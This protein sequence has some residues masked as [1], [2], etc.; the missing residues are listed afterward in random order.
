MPKFFLT[1]MILAL[2]PCCLEVE[3]SVPGFPQM[4]A[5]FAASDAMIQGTLAVNFIGFCIGSLFWG[6]VAESWGKRKA[7][8]SG[9]TVLLA[10]AIGCVLAPSINTLL[11]ARFF[12]GIGASAAAVLVFSM[13]A[14]RFEGEKAARIIGI[15]NAILTTLMALAPVIGALVNQWIGWQGNYA[16]L[17]AICSI[18]WLALL[19]FLPET[20]HTHMPFHF[21]TLLKTIKNLLTLQF[22]SLA[23][24]PSLL[25]AGYLSFIG[26]ATFLYQVT[27]QLSLAS[28]ALHQFLIIGT[29]AITSL[30]AAAITQKLGTKRT[31]HGAKI[32]CYSSIGSLFLISLYMPE[33]NL[34][35]VCMMGFCIG[36]ALYYPPIFTASMAIFPNHTGIASSLLMSLRTALTSSFISLTAFSFEGSLFSLT[37]PLLAIVA[38]F[39]ICNLRVKD[40]ITS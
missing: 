12:Q 18:S 9:S 4:A 10:G 37:L 35:T 20:S 36:F 24:A 23:T 5:Y 32:L 31:L 29:F 33:A 15:M 13:I 6:P 30:Y 2:I 1:L 27:F 19:L 3:I 7:L 14:D 25:Y 17:C 28:Y 16:L 22:F 39:Y 21:S 26:T 11:F 34:V 8:L 40:L 38:I